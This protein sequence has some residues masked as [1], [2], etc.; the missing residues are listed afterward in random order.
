VVG[1]HDDDDVRPLVVDEVEA[2]EDRVG[3]A[4]VPVLVDPLLRGTGAT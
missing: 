1:P 3:R 4:E 2:L